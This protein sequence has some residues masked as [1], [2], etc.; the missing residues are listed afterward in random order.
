MEIQHILDLDKVIEIRQKAIQNFSE[1]NVPKGTPNSVLEDVFVPLYFFHRYQTEA[2]AKIIGGMDYNYSLVG[3]NQNE[4][5]YLD[6]D[7]QLEAL[8]SLV[9]TLSP[10]F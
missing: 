5:H 3:D 10:I 4:F 8:N 9:K 2:T 6:K 7:T 1:Y